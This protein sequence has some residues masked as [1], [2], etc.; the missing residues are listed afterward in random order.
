MPTVAIKTKGGASAGE[1][2]LSERVFGAKVNIP[3][4]HQAVKAEL[5]NSRQDTRN[6]PGRGDMLGGGKKPFKQK[7]TG[8]ARQG[9]TVAPH[10]RKGGAAHGPHPRDLG[11]ALPKKMRRAAIRAALSAKL[12]DGELIVVDA[13]PLDGAISTKTAATFIREVAPTAKKSLVIIE[14]GDDSVHKS[15][16]NIANVTIR[17]APVFSTRDVIDGGVII[18]TRAAAEKVDAQ[19]NDGKPSTAISAAESVTEATPELEGGE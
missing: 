10:W 16:R 8:R 7:G 4:M 17:T 15:L 2:A 18:I 3:L 5:E 6:A 19:W 1:I 14:S 11:H 13:F 12:A 9:S